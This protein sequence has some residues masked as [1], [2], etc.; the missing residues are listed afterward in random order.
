MKVRTTP[1][2]PFLSL[3]SSILLLF[4]SYLSSKTI[5]HN[6]LTSTKS[7]TEDVLRI[8]EL[9][10]T[11]PELS[12]LIKEEQGLSM[13][14]YYS[15]CTGKVYTQKYWEIYNCLWESRKRGRKE[16]E[17]IKEG[18]V[19]IEGK[20]GQ[21]QSLQ[22]VM[23][24]PP[25]FDSKHW[26]YFDFMAEYEQ[27]I[28]R[29]AHEQAVYVC[30]EFGRKL[31]ERG[32]INEVEETK[33]L[34]GEIDDYERRWHH[35]CNTLT[36]YPLRLHHKNMTPYI[37][38]ITLLILSGITVLLVCIVRTLAVL[39]R[40]DDVSKRWRDNRYEKTRSEDDKNIGRSN[41]LRMKKPSVDS[42]AKAYSSMNYDYSDYGNYG[43]PMG[44]YSSGGPRYVEAMSRNMGY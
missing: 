3:L 7:Q 26:L 12:S 21:S 39:E 5:Y 18:E 37:V 30:E 20:S 4:P 33:S 8:L 13:G 42:S 38:K 10:T 32:W 28:D 19:G 31:K 36:A 29:D 27:L 14:N 6:A 17:G 44:M 35:K 41:D 11:F 16:K 22:A 43:D 15:N 40:Y 1:T 25:L 24:G 9:K 23:A 2:P 34:D